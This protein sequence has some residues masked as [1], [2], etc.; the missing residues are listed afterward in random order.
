MA[1][2]Y[3]LMQWLYQMF[4][5]SLNESQPLTHIYFIICNKLLHCISTIGCNLK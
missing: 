3:K 4:D 1:L 5:G 2:N